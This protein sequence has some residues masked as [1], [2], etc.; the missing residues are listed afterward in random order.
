MSLFS[1]SFGRP[2]ADDVDNFFLHV[3]TSLLG[4][5][6]SSSP[7]SV[8]PLQRKGVRGDEGCSQVH[9]RPNQIYFAVAD[10]SFRH[11]S[12]QGDGCSYTSTQCSGSVTAGQQWADNQVQRAGLL[13]G[14]A[15]GLFTSAS[16]DASLSCGSL[17]S[18]NPLLPCINGCRSPPPACQ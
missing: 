18:R 4:P 12:H 14:S 2:N 10:S 13:L 9:W 5:R 15:E 11:D 3:E 17:H 1:Y 6:N 8:T 7:S 16:I